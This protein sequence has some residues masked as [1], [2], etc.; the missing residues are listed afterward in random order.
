[1]KTKYV[2]ASNIRVV[3]FKEALS[4]LT[5]RWKDV[6]FTIVHDEIVAFGNLTSS[7]ATKMEAQV[8]GFDAGFDEGL[9]AGF[10]AGISS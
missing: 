4:F 8:E 7:Q 6:N 2:I 3:Y 5:K 9:K 1:M 10:D